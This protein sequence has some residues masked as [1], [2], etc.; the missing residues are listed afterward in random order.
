MILEHSPHQEPLARAGTGI[1]SQ[2]SD[3]IYRVCQPI[4]VGGASYRRFTIEQVQF[5]RPGS[6]ALVS[7]KILRRFVSDY[8]AKILWPHSSE[9]LPRVHLLAFEGRRQS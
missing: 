9:S 1:C 2:E 5:R 6:K 7:G 3:T 4:D 8:F